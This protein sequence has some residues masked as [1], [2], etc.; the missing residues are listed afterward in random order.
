MKG[1][2]GGSSAQRSSRGPWEDLMA[3]ASAFLEQSMNA[4]AAA[5]AAGCMVSISGNQAA[6]TG[7]EIADGNSSPLNV[8]QCFQSDSDQ[9]A[10]QGQ[11]S[12]WPGLMV[13]CDPTG[14]MCV[15]KFLLS[16]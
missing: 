16:Q 6:H 1:D 12:I 9:S 10:N 7:T 15:Y 11:S 8:E 2:L 5:A 13:N 3:E 4:A 14:S